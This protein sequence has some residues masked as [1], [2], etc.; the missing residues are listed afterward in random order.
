MSA[1]L[2]LFTALGIALPQPLPDQFHADPGTTQV[3]KFQVDSAA[4]GGTNVSLPQGIYRIK[5]SGQYTFAFGISEL[6]YADAECS[7]SQTV[8]RQWVRDQYPTSDPSGDSLD[9]YVDNKAIEW[10]PTN[11]SA[12]GTSVS[13]YVQDSSPECDSRDIRTSTH[14]YSAG[15]TWKGGTLNLKVRDDDYSNNSGVL[16]VI[17][18]SFNAKQYNEDLIAIV[19]L[20]SW[21]PTGI[22]SP[23]LIVGKTY[24]FEISGTYQ[25]TGSRQTVADAEC[26]I[27]GPGAL[28]EQKFDANEG[29]DILDVH[30]NDGY[31]NGWADGNVDWTPTSGGAA[32]SCA[33][34]P[35]HTYTY[36]YQAQDPRT[37]TGGP[38]RSITKV[39]MMVFDSGYL[40]NSGTLTVKIFQEELTP[41]RVQA[42]PA[43]LAASASAAVD[44]AA[45]TVRASAGV[46]PSLPAPPC[47]R[48]ALGG[49]LTVNVDTKLPNGAYTSV[50]LTP[51][52]YRARV[53]GVWQYEYATYA[54]GECSLGPVVILPDDKTTWLRNRF[55]YTSIGKDPLDLLIS[56]VDY[57]W[58]PA[59]KPAPQAQDCENSDPITS[60]ESHIYSVDFTW[61][62][63]GH[64]NAAPMRF[65]VA[66][67][68]YTR[69][70]GTLKVELFQTPTSNSAG[71][72]VGEVA[73]DTASPLGIVTPP[74]I[75]GKQYRLEVSGNYTYYAYSASGW[76][77]DAECSTTGSDL[78]PSANRYPDPRGGDPLDVYVDDLQSDNL[79]L[80]GPV[81]W[82]PMGASTV[83]GC[84]ND[85]SYS[86]TFA[87]TDSGPLQ[88]KIFEQQLDWYEDNVG[89][90]TAKLFLMS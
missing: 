16:N 10:S 76:E 87:A 52:N 48:D 42:D 13:P 49:C 22:D 56:G 45:A 31:P 47:V 28:W 21:L 41:A 86:L 50:G 71:T 85:H 18:E 53:T 36:L 62:G 25:F 82:I 26:F 66:D 8:S 7:Q 90:L 5:I 63:D 72:L 70:N 74:V 54:D 83:S 39:N 20:P 3:L 9:V 32:K 88:L 81:R 37:A 80:D 43:S 78:V 77:A 65:N 29:N 19:S 23:E 24:R 73:L 2:M 89:V 4:R 69:N 84:S 75:A 40:D 35:S 46:V 55:A 58:A 11:N 67:T 44:N 79:I 68:E 34:D 64:G 1:F 15:Y 60:P 12:T 61:N 27:R 17:V 51:G 57:E 14:E 33:S 6:A 38:T 30:L 59:S